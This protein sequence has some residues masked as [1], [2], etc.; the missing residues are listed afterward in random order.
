MS[1]NIIK[2]A[3]TATGTTTENE[4]IIKSDGA[5]SDVMQWLSNN[6]ASNITISEDGSNNLDLVVSSGTV[7]VGG[8]FS[9]PV[10]VAHISSDGL[11]RLYYTS[12]AE[13]IH[14]SGAS[15]GL[16]HS[17]R[18]TGGTT[19]ADISSTGLTVTGG[20]VET[21]GVLKENLLT[22]SGFDV[23]S[24]STLV[25]ATSGAAPVTDGANSAL[26]NNKLTNGGF[27]SDASSWSGLDATLASVTGG[28][29]GNCLQVT[30]T[31]AGF[32]YAQQ[33]GTAL[34][35]G[36]LYQLSAYVKSGSSG[37]EAFQVYSHG[38]QG[39]GGGITGTSSSSWVLYTTVF[40]ATTTSATM[41]VG[42]Q[43]ATAGTM[44]FDTVCLYEVTPKCTSTDTCDGWAAEGT[45]AHGVSYRQHKDATFTKD[46]SFY[47]LKFVSHA[48][49]DNSVYQVPFSSVSN[50][51]TMSSPEVLARVAGRTVT[52]GAWVY[53][54]SGAADDVAVFISDSERGYT[55]SQH[56]VSKYHTA[57]TGWEWLEVTYTFG[58]SPS[59]ATVGFY[60]DAGTTTSYM[61]QPMLVFGSAIGA[62]N[63]S[64]PS[65]EVIYNEVDYDSV[66]YADA[67]TLT[68]NTT[69]NSEAE[70]L[71]RIPKG[72]KAL[73]VNLIGSPDAVGSYEAYLQIYDPTWA[74]GLR[75]YGNV[76]G[77]RITCAG[78]VK[79]NSAGEYRVGKNQNFSELKL[80]F[81]GVQM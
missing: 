29:T 8:V 47:S 65:G 55:P 4:P 48:T 10:A 14:N 25:E 37:D 38:S 43:S 3:I 49:A 35:V 19:V 56:D 40:E 77:N 81:L 13:T 6:E 64:R 69:F 78:W 41:I 30:R 79:L 27:D 39:Y 58:A 59:A 62:G 16:L 66:S 54:A 36:K 67:G 22:N 57:A 7:T 73:N 23:W 50:S 31:G 33:D 46:G 28:K 12:S 52:F 68:S 72:A 70:S 60:F 1:I 9:L 11:Q 18:N 61:S 51:T 42:K 74:T 26:T 34:V 44:L 15:T 24:N 45:T 2:K 80:T 76:V 53:S 75:T 71:G 17:F 21:N 5:S 20:I 32:N 63:Y